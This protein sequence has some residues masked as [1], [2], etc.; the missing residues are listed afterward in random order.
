MAWIVVCLAGAFSMAAALSYLAYM[1]N[2]VAAGEL[3]GLPGSDV[4]VAI[5]QHQAVVWL[6]AAA[7][8]QSAAVSAFFSLLSLL[9]VGAEND[10][11]IRWT[12]R[13]AVATFLSFV[14]TLGI[15]IIV[16]ETLNLL[17]LLNGEILG[18]D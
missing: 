2:G 6:V 5:S 15:G 7:V 11:I 17:G 1:A 12:S 16:F 3:T 14:T 10:H 18:Q 9:R 8:F 4:D 13:G